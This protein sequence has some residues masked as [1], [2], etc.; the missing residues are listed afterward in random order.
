VREKWHLIGQCLSKICSKRCSWSNVEVRAAAANVCNFTTVAEEAIVYWLFVSEGEDWLK[1]FQRKETQKDS[2]VGE[3]EEFS[4]SGSQRK[5]CGTHK[6]IEYLKHWYQLR[7]L[8]QERRDNRE[9]SESWDDAW[10]EFACEEI[11]LKKNKKGTRK[12]SIKD[13]LPKFE[14]VL[15]VGKPQGRFSSGIVLDVFFRHCRL[16]YFWISMVCCRDYTNNVIVKMII[17][18]SENVSGAFLETFGKSPQRNRGCF[19]KNP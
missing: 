16:R 1:E 8:V 11:A 2:S 17:F 15:G 14:D 4:N 10:R 9:I 19:W 3:G 5:K 18:V 13:V 7:E 6:S 12:R